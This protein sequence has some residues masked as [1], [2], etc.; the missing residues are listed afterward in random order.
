DPNAI[1][2]ECSGVFGKEEATIHKNPVIT[3]KFFSASFT[4]DVREAI[5]HVSSCYPDANLY[6][7]GWSLG[8]NFLVKNAI[9]VSLCSPFNLVLTDE[10]LNKG[11]NKVYS[12][13]LG[14]SLSKVF[15]R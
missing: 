13:V 2:M 7:D 12:K 10:D 3:P 9:G 8:A 1:Y 5:S 15:R 14:A 4:G 11:F 6:A